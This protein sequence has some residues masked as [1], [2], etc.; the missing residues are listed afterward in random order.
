MLL[1][2]YMLSAS[3]TPQSVVS[4]SDPI[5]LDQARRQI[6]VTLRA[7]AKEPAEQTAVFDPPIETPVAEEL[8]VVAGN[9]GQGRAQVVYKTTAGNIR[10]TYR[11]GAP[12]PHPERLIDIAAGTRYRLV[13]CEPKTEP[14]R[15]I[16]VEQAVLRVEEG[17]AKHEDGVTGVAVTFYDFSRL[18]IRPG[19]RVAEPVRLVTSRRLPGQIVIDASG[20]R[21]ALA[22]PAAMRSFAD[23]EEFY[24]F[25]VREFNAK[26]AYDPTGK[27]LVGATLS[28]IRIGRPSAVTLDGHFFKVRDAMPALIGGETRA[29]NIAGRVIDVPSGE[30]LQ[31][32]GFTGW[33]CCHKLVDDP[34]R[35]PEMRPYCHYPSRCGS[36][37]ICEDP[38]PCGASG[39]PCCT[40]D[41]PCVLGFRCSAVDPSAGVCQEGPTGTVS[42]ASTGLTSQ[43]SGC[44]TD[45]SFCTEEESYDNEYVVKRTIGAETTITK[46]GYE[47][48]D[49]LCWRFPFPAPFLCT[50]RSGW[51]KLTLDPAFAVTGDAGSCG[52]FSPG[53]FNFENVEDADFSYEAWGLAKITVSNDGSLGAA[54]VGAELPVVGVKTGHFSQGAPTGGTRNAATAIGDLC[55]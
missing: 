19:F 23:L 51:S 45:G 34:L 33:A 2:A 7:D 54:P 3:G 22:V 42:A 28:V 25:L 32:C 39:Q 1:F 13:Q 15:P 55:H 20:S 31:P 40:T 38:P 44:S 27:R 9:A 26:P 43:A 46:G 24:G 4:P 29:I 36:G 18:E 17:D 47:E 30:H 6:T 14:D 41:P 53:P 49:Y 37:L 48:H 11:G 50:R 10:C 21:N 12:L 8:T 5:S 52:L 35:G 16:R